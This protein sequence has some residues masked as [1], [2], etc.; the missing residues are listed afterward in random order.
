MKLAE[1]LRRARSNLY[2]L[3]ENTE[4]L[5]R[6]TSLADLIYEQGSRT[7]QFYEEKPGKVSAR[8]VE[9]IPAWF[10]GLEDVERREYELWCAVS[11]IKSLIECLQGS[12]PEL[13]ELYALKY[14]DKKPLPDVKQRFA[15]K[16]KKLDQDL[17]FMVILWHSWPVD[18]EGGDEFEKW[19]KNKGF[20]TYP[21]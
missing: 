15:G 12:E 17:I 7:E 3:K 10:L 4:L 13:C 5:K 9:S 8:Y 20:L 21:H 11:V 2:R 16:L 1:A 6:K 14:R 18:P 19:R